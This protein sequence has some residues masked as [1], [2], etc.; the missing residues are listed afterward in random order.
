MAGTPEYIKT[1]Q[2][3]SVTNKNLNKNWA[4]DMKIT[5]PK[6]IYGY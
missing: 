6:K 5:L 3:S 2:N 4:Y 1:S